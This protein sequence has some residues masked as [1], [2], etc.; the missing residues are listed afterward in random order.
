M[1]SCGAKEKN[2]K[3]KQDQRLVHFLMG[4]HESYCAARGNILVISP[5]PSISNAYALL[6]QEEKQRELQN[7]PKFP[8]ESSSFIAIS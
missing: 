8:G 5:L 4:L 1:C 2:I 6:I 3:A 7:I